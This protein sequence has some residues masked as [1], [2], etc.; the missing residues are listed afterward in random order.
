MFVNCFE[1]IILVIKHLL[2]F[3]PL[4]EASFDTTQ[5]KDQTIMKLYCPYLDID[6][7][8]NNVYFFFLCFTILKY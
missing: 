7:T 8:Y 4:L 6:Q 3:M 2:T 5:M 1:L